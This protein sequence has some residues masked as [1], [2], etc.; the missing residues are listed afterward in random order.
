MGLYDRAVIGVVG[1][2]LEG[3]GVVHIDGEMD[4]I[5]ASRVEK[6]DSHLDVAYGRNV[7][8][9][10]QQNLLGAPAFAHTVVLELEAD[11]M[12]YHEKIPFLFGFY[13]M[14]LFYY[15]TAADKNQ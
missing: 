11:Y 5:G 8:D 2:G 12:S 4:V 6:I 10:R 1:I 9:H 7:A 14:M 15:T 13:D 3:V